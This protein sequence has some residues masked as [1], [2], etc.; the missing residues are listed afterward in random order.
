LIDTVGFLAGLFF[1]ISDKH[2]KSS[3]IVGTVIV[4]LLG[5][6]GRAKLVSVAIATYAAIAILSTTFLFDWIFGSLG[7][8]FSTAAVV[9]TVLLV[10]AL[11]YFMIHYGLGNILSED[12][13]FIASS[14][15][16]A[17]TIVGMVFMY[18]LTILPP[19]ILSGFSNALQTVFTGS[20]SRVL[21]F[22]APIIVI[23]ATKD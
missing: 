8:A 23:G 21:W 14:I 9:I 1:I 22:L 10:T 7:V 17:I 11:L 16:L 3:I 15:I 4:V 12:R 5:F 19:D 13:G 2:S 6:W 18:S 20:V